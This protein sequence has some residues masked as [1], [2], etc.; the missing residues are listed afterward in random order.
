MSIKNMAVEISR[1]E[2]GAVQMNI[3]EIS[4]V[5]GILSDLCAEDSGN[6]ATL[7]NNGIRRRKRGIVPVKARRA[8]K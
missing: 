5:L 7:I 8:A 4:E 6:V 3:A 2:G 1:R